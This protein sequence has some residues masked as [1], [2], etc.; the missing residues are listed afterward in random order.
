MA[1][2][3][4]LFHST[5]LS[6]PLSPSALS[7]SFTLMYHE[8]LRLFYVHY[9]ESDTYP[10]RISISFASDV[11]VALFTNERTS[12]FLMLVDFLSKVLNHVGGAL[13]NS[14]RS[15]ASA[16]RSLASP[17]ITSRLSFCINF[18]ARAPN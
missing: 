16:K 4:F 3:L 7:L 1:F 5:S 8:L 10:N 13:L 2:A 14:D 6:L 15:Q 12:V 11:W 17:P 9:Q 18:V